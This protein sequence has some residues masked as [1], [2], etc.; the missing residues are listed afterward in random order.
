QVEVLGVSAKTGKMIEA[1]LASQPKLPCHRVVVVR[2][3]QRFLGPQSFKGREL[4]VA[5]AFDKVLVPRAWNT[6][7]TARVC[8]LVAVGSDLSQEEC[9][10]VFRNE[11]CTV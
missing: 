10:L 3:R 1:R 2:K 6:A 4:D 7:L 9:K 5:D 11:D 8:I